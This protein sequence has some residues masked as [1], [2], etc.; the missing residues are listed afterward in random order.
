VALVQFVSLFRDGQGIDVDRAGQ[1]VTLRELRQE[2]G[3]TCASSTCC[4]S[5]TRRSIS[6]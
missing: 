2:V 5:K 3:T 6:T 1:Y 4:A